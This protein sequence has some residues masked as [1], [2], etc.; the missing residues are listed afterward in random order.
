MDALKETLRLLRKKAGLSQSELAELAGLSRTAIQALE[1][2]KQTCKLITLFKVMQVLNL[3][4]FADHALL[5]DEPR[6]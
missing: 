1:D 3:K 5:K 4:L 6:S 2:G